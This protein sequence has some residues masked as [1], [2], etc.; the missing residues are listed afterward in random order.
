MNRRSFFRSL[1]IAT[2]ALYLRIA[3]SV[4][5]GLEAAKPIDAPQTAVYDDSFHL[6]G[7]FVHHKG[8]VLTHEQMFEINR[9]KTAP[10]RAAYLKNCPKFDDGKLVPIWNPAE[11]RYDIDTRTFPTT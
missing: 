10:E 3:P 2:A 7:G 8:A 5:K 11:N 4:C 1:G 9:I 6:E